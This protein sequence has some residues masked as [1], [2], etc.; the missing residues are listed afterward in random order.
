MS[1]YGQ[2]ERNHFDFFQ[3]C[4]SLLFSQLVAKPDGIEALWKAHI[5]HYLPAFKRLPTAAIE[6]APMLV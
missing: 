3:Y 4:P 2:Q 5:P 6:K 1:G